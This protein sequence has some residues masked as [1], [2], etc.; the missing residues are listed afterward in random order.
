MN[1]EVAPSSTRINVGSLNGIAFAP[2]VYFGEAGFVHG[3]A[4]IRSVRPVLGS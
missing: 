3:R 4:F 2:D 1:D